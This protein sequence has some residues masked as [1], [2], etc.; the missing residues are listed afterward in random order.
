M[1]HA[2]AVIM[3]ACAVPEEIILEYVYYLEKLRRF[4]THCQLCKRET[5]TIFKCS[6][7]GQNFCPDHRLPENHR[8]PS[9]PTSKQW[10]ERDKALEDKK[11]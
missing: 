7:C 5:D 3:H 1:K 8:C 4:M 11:Q 9:M 10:R 6:Y 2:R